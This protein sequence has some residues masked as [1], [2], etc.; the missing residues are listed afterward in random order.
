MFR[1][2][3]E[4]YYD[5]DSPINWPLVLLQFLVIDFF[6][7]TNHLLEH[8]FPSLYKVSHKFHHVFINPKIYNA[9][10]G[11]VPDTISLILIPLVLT[12]Q[13][14]RSVNCWSYIAFGSL[15]ATV[16]TLI[17]CEFSHPWD[18]LFYYI[19][20]G[21]AWDHNVHHA[22]FIYNYG[23]FFMYWDWL[24]GTYKNPSTCEALRIS[25]LQDD[26]EKK[27]K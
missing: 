21:T 9:F 15:Y 14:C 27:L 10:N 2:M 3:P 8:Y 25:G 4:S 6:T 18:Y 19:G 17:H 23:H 7:F 20:V 22:L 5:L 24:W 11:S 13:I 16:F 26:K 1:I 12:A